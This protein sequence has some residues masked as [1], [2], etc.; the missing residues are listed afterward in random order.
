MK[1]S[2]AVLLLLGLIN[3]KHHHRDAV[4]LDTAESEA[5]SLGSLEQA[6]LE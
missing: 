4:L 6:Y 5:G 3:A 1:T 2:I